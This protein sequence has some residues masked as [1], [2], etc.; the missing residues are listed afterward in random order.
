MHMLLRFFSLTHNDI[1]LFSDGDV[2]LACANVLQQALL[3]VA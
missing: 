1:A 3:Q 2:L